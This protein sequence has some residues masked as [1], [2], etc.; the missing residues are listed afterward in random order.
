M[1][2]K[3][4]SSLE[5]CFLDEGLDDK[6]EYNSGSCLKNERYHFTVAYSIG[7]GCI[8]NK[9]L[10]FDI[11][12]DLKEYIT[13]Y[14][15]EHTP[16]HIPCYPNDMDDN[17][18]RTKPG[19][20]PDLLVPVS[21]GEQLALSI[22]TESLYVEVDP[23]GK[24]GAG[25]YPITITLFNKDGTEWDS[26]TFTLEIINALLPEQDLIHTEW[27]HC[28]C[29]SEYYGTDSFDER[30]WAIIENFIAA[31]V[32]RGINMILTPVFT[33]P[34]DTAV[35]GERKTTQLVGVSL[36]NGKY[37]FDF[38]LLGRWVD[39]CD[40]LGV[41]YFEIS[42]L[43]TQWGAAHAPKVMATVDGEYKKIFGWE[44]DA[45]GE[46]YKAF[47]NAFVPAFLAFMRS[48]NNAD[49][50]CWFHVSDEP[51]RNHLEQYK[52]SYAVVSDLLKNYPVIDALSDYDFYKEGIV[53]NP[54]P[55]SDHIT[56]FIEN[57]VPDLWVYYCCVERKKVSNR[58]LSMPSARNRIIGLQMYKYDIKGFLQWGYNFYKSQYSLR[59]VN[60]F[61][62]TDG[63]NFVPSGDTF[64]VYP[65]HDGKPYESL[66]FLVFE[67]ALQDMR[68]MK[69]LEGICG[70][71]TVLEII[72]KGIDPITFENYPHSAEWLLGIRDQINKQIKKN[73]Q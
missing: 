36:D 61:L 45:C 46:E 66:R 17:Y 18:L 28:D 15:I 16:V 27:F 60:P 52:K 5:K 65:A 4:L 59:P 32:K 41:K 22:N 14:K 44:T 51:G 26:A 23:N 13:V 33:P 70:K 3:I 6:Q 30:H 20:Y 73:I 21:V 25:E 35:G 62:R 56:P 39:M 29:L 40:R 8:G 34:L 72:E 38:S 48:K 63:E 42:H 7:T 68:A 31:A 49:K 19:L 69:L 2:L 47:L 50:R 54:I 58:F 53:K 12:S 57:N 9:Y 1:A 71:K 10:T 43:F 11:A 64:L 37:A 67:E 55:A 24:V